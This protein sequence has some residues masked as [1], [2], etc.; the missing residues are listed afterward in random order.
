[1]THGNS[2]PTAATNC[3]AE[4]LLELRAAWPSVDMSN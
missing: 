3:D 2:T 4:T 1:M